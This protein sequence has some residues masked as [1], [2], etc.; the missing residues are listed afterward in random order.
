MA[1]TIAQHD[2]AAGSS[3]P[4]AAPTPSGPPI[5]SLPALGGTL[6]PDELDSRLA[7]GSLDG[8]IVVIEGELTGMFEPC[9]SVYGCFALV[10][11][12]GSVVS[13]DADPRR[14]RSSNVVVP[15]PGELVFAAS[16]G[17]LN[18]LGPEPADVD[19]PITVA[20]LMTF[21]QIARSDAR[22]GLARDGGP[23]VLRPDRAG[24]DTVS[25][26][27]PW[28]TDDR[29]ARRRGTRVGARGLPS[30]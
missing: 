11:P 20:Q 24:R 22:L 28:L 14:V 16:H 1:A 18:Y 25:Q 6:S 2:T 7:D 30:R 12:G 15:G 29:P 4:S 8:R 27:A 13:I 21:P 26:C 5:I 9:P 23:D 10:L 17:V 3:A 19:H